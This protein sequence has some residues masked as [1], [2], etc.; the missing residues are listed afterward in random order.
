MLFVPVKS[1]LRM[2]KFFI[3]TITF[4]FFVGQL[5]TVSAQAELPES[6]LEN[7]R[8]SIY[9]VNV[10]LDNKQMPTDRKAAAENYTMDTYSSGLK[11]A[12]IIMVLSG[13]PGGKNTERAMSLEFAVAPVEGNEPKY[14]QA[15][16]VKS[17][18]DGQYRVVLRPGRYWIGPK[19][20]ALDA[21]H[22][23]PSMGSFTEKIVTVTE[24]VFTQIDLSEIRY[25]P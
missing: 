5:L 17:G 9:E 19:A 1:R 3:M 11:G 21:E 16:F 18:Q 8:A 25:A 7:Q 14:D 20:K 12:T 6:F 24:G 2:K 10:T 13:V 22:Y 23:I 15:T 4:F